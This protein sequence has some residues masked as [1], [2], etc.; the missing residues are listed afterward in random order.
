MTND[1]VKKPS[2]LPPALVNKIAD[3][4][5]RSYGGSSGGITHGEMLL[6]LDKGGTGW[7]VGMN[8]QSMEPV[9]EGSR[10]FVNSQ[11]FKWGW[12]VWSESKKVY[13][14]MIDA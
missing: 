2:A 10:W 9:E 14:S 6:K 1:I 3:G 13:E 11:T 8:S 5:A 12:V 7:G 4:L